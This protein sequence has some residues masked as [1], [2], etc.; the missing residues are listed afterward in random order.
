FGFPSGVSA[1]AQPTVVSGRVF[2]GS[3][4]G[5]VYSMDAKTGCVY[6]SFETGSIIR[7]AVVVGPVKN[8]DGNADARYAVFVGD[9]HAN[10][11]AV[12]AQTGK[13]LWKTKVDPHF[14]ARITAGARYYD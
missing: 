11:F 6:W 8:V 12:N 3:D 4:N 9:G 7:N 2:V 13:L 5:Y 1:N 10:V 14:V